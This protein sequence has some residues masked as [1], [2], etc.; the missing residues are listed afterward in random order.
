MPIEYLISGKTPFTIINPMKNILEEIID[1]ETDKLKK[2]ELIFNWMQKNITYATTKKQGKEYCY[3]PAHEVFLSKSGICF[4]Q[5]ILYTVLARHAGINSAIA[6]IYINENNKKS[7]HACSCI[8]IKGDLYFVDTAK[9]KFDIQHKGYHLWD[10]KKAIENYFKWNHSYN[11]EGKTDKKQER[12]R[13]IFP[14]NRIKQIKIPEFSFQNEQKYDKEESDKTEE[15]NKTEEDE[16]IRERKEANKA[17]EINETKESDKIEGMNT[18]KREQNFYHQDPAT[19]Y[20][21]QNHSIRN[22]LLTSV[23][24]CAVGTGIYFTI[25]NLAE[26][27]RP[28]L[29]W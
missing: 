29:S 9:N 1:D 19:K 13:A 12:F 16:K 14:R 25:S 7:N 22:I 23:I 5:A 28:F 26:N 2:A 21:H 6:D 20:Y 18:N 10:D 8:E 15:D 3:R 17:K 4:D 24:L 11:N 27:Y